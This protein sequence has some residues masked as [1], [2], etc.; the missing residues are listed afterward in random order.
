MMYECFDPEFDTVF[1][2]DTFPEVSPEVVGFRS[3]KSALNTY[4]LCRSYTTKNHPEYRLSKIEKKRI[5]SYVLDIYYNYSSW[6][7]EFKV[8]D[9]TMVVIK[10]QEMIY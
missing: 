4:K 7:T 5:N 1:V 6:I 10:E 9:A 2:V 3:E 8:I